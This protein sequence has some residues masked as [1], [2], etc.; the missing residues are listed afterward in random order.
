MADIKWSAFPSIGNLATGDV[1]VGL[2]AGANVR[3]NA[4]TIP[5]TVPNGGTGLITATAYA[6]LTGGT[7]ATGSFQSLTTGTSGQL[8]QSNGSSALPTW[9]S[10]SFPTGSG[11]LNHMLR[12]DGT[13]WVQTTATTLDSSDNFAGIASVAMAGTISGATALRSAGG[14]NIA[15][16]TANALAV[17]YLTLTS[18]ASG[19]AAGLGSAGG[20]TN[21]DLRYFPKAAG[22]HNFIST[23]SSPVIF[24]T[25]TGYQR[26]ST[27]VFSNVA[28]SY[29]YTFP[30]ATGTLALTSD[31]SGFISTIQ[32]NTGSVTPT[33]NTVSITGGTTGLTTSG[34]GSTLILTGTLVV[35]NGGTGTATAPS[36]GQIPIGTSGGVY[37]PAAINSGSGIIV[38]NGSG[39]ITVSATGGGVSWTSIA[40]TTQA[41][42]VNSGYIVANASQTTITL[43]ATAAIGDTVKIRGLGAAG[44]ILAANTGQTIKYVTAT[45]SSGGS[46]T[47]AE[48]YDNIEVTCI[49]ANTTWTV[50]SAAT[51]GLT[52]A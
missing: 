22:V 8:L 25:G 15:T 42:A 30:D 37:T 51:T 3:F 10:A 36:A 34:S 48:Q 47:S 38:A 14:L 45:T 6:I 41:A 40:G 11:T 52:I 39:T 31:I 46:L 27:F 12:S 9:T 7:T 50:A 44:W 13:N 19:N 18:V 4:L 1:L 49:V 29:S 2:R 17:N 5:W 24:Q 35:G 21:V 20:D 23:N 28:S 16:L 26:T 32:G 43:P 33:S